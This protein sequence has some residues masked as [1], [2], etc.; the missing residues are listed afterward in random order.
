MNQALRAHARQ[1]CLCMLLNCFAKPS[2]T[3]EL[4]RDATEETVRMVLGACYLAVRNA[5]AAPQPC[6][7]DELALRVLRC[8]ADHVLHHVLAALVLEY[9]R[10]CL[11]IAYAVLQKRR[12]LFVQYLKIYAGA[13]VHEA[14]SYAES[15]F[16]VL[17][18]C[19]DQLPPALV[20]IL[21]TLDDIKFNSE[22][23]EILSPSQ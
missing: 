20:V 1:D 12:E 13:E 10:C 5:F 4:S 21:A 18:Y 23:Y 8:L 11:D 22:H 6:E 15:S 2:L 9:T 7:A 3:E 16:S 19:R 17:Q 14:M